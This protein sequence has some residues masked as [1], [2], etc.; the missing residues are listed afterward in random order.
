[1]DGRSPLDAGAQWEAGEEEAGVYSVM[2]LSD[3]RIK[4][5]AVG[6]C[7]V[8]HLLLQGRRPGHV[9]LLEAP[10]LVL[11]AFPWAQRT[12]LSAGEG[13]LG[14]MHAQLL[15]HVTATSTP[16]L[17]AAHAGW[18]KACAVVVHV[19]QQ[20]PVQGLLRLLLV[21][22]ACTMPLLHWYKARGAVCPAGTLMQKRGWCGRHMGHSDYHRC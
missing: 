3:L 18:R 10:P 12:P 21:L 17:A 19:R 6:R 9:S 14:A 7:V 20:G 4:S 2:Q 5:A 15:M 11:W 16:A 1:M 22:H 8:W 13:P